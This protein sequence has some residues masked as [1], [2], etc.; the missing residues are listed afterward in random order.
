MSEDKKDREWK[1]FLEKHKEEIEF[2]DKLVEYLNKKYES[3]LEY[4]NKKHF[5]KEKYGASVLRID[6]KIELEI[7][8]SSWYDL[9]WITIFNEKLT[10]GFPEFRSTEHALGDI[11]SHVLEEIKNK[12][13][14]EKYKND[15]T[16]GDEIFLYERADEIAS[17]VNKKY[18]TNIVF[19][20]G[21]DCWFETTFSIKDK[22]LEEVIK[23]IERN[24][25]PLYE[26]SEKA[27][28][29]VATIYNLDFIF[30]KPVSKRTAKQIEKN[31]K[32]RSL[33]GKYFC[34]P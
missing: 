17:E 32:S 22:S 29:I 23:E 10:V 3:Y 15:E 14:W 18:G 2:A 6:D 30:N 8:A 12:E 26:A 16:F 25:P 9:P 19:R 1:A 21:E 24:I 20:G 4:L 33:F 34:Y 28:K 7:D 11:S 27:C 31:T 5:R 13:N